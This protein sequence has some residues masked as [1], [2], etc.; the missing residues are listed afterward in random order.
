MDELTLNSVMN[1]IIVQSSLFK[2]KDTRSTYEIVQAFEEIPTH[3][4]IKFEKI[5]TFEKIAAAS[6]TFFLYHTT[7]LKVVVLKMVT[8]IDIEGKEIYPVVYVFVFA[9]HCKSNNSSE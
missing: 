5:T 4:R 7:I 6:I 2:K 8:Y 1:A 3:L 9:F